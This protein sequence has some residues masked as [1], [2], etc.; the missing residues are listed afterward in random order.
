M[1][2]LN[3]SIKISF[4][5]NQKVR[6]KSS[7]DYCTS[8]LGLLHNRLDIYLELYFNLWSWKPISILIPKAR[9]RDTKVNQQDINCINPPYGEIT[10]FYNLLYK[11]IIQNIGFFVY[12]SRVEDIPKLSYW[13]GTRI[14]S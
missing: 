14:M 1:G 5:L 3:L 11:I 4:V 9:T 6:I 8:P 2:D 7:K 10:Q 13:Y 12:E